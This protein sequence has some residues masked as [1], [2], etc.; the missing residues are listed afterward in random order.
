[1]YF[2]SSHRETKMTPN[3]HLPESHAT[4]WVPRGH[5]KIATTPE[6]FLLSHLAW[7]GHV[8]LPFPPL[9][10]TTYITILYIYSQTIL[11][12]QIQIR[13]RIFLLFYFNPLIVNN[14][15]VSIFNLKE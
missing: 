10:P 13:Y 5:F 6:P 11:K 9:S 1:M 15:V 14:G 12:I 7:L 8:D 3:S 4:S 2:H